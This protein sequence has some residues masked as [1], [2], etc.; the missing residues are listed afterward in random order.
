MLEVLILFPIIVVTL[1]VLAGIGFFIF[2]RGYKITRP[3]EAMIIVKKGGVQSKKEAASDTD[4]DAEK[5]IKEGR[6]DDRGISVSTSACWVNPI[7]AKVYRFPTGIN[8]TNFEVDCY[9]KLKIPLR[10]KGVLLYKVGENIPSILAA[11]AR[12][13]DFDQKD[14]DRAIGDLVTGQLRAMVGETTIEDLITNR[15]GLTLKVRGATTEDMAKLG[16]QIDSLVIQDLTDDYDYIKNL[17]APQAEAVARQASIAADEARKERAAATNK[18]DLEISEIERSTKVK[19]AEF[20]AE[21]DRAQEEAGQS[22]PLARAR[23]EKD[24]VIEQTAVAEMEAFRVEK[25]LDAD[26]RRVSE[27]DRYAAE[28]RADA[29]AYRVTKEVEAEVKA[30]EDRGTAQASA[31]EAI[32]K[33]EAA[34][35]EARA[36][37]LAENGELLIQ[38]KLASQM[39]EIVSAAAA[40]IAKIKSMVVTDGAEGIG[41]AIVSSIA[42]AGEAVRNVQHGLLTEVDDNDVA[43][44]AA[45]AVVSAVAESPSAA[46][47]AAAGY[48]SE[49]S[50]N[51]VKV[52][53]GEP[54]SYDRVAVD[55]GV[56]A[57]ES[58][59]DQADDLNQFSDGITAALE[60]SQGEQ[61][62][63]AV[64]FLSENE[65]DLRD[66]VDSKGVGPGTS[67]AITRLLKG[68]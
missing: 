15:Q 21:Q 68:L 60:G 65:Q 28:Q 5:A 48:R 14:M 51:E 33:A 42:V 3:N 24:V 41:Q 8:T 67:K 13:Q 46:K 25:R 61:L 43:S 29:E 22:G 49:D 18:A 37:A 4:L 57:I 17:G 6:I 45:G 50:A 7:T 39:P 38:E 30:I 16:L 32:S 53:P 19:Q 62:R 31:I 40:P 56:N 55:E 10:V 64:E 27:A 66:L 52:D 23:A 20:K 35:I 34:G 9:D 63:K 11:V 26:V 44:S 47:S 54:R 1:I 59:I 12:F 36:A 2:R 58:L